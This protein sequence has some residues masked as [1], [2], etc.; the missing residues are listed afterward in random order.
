MMHNGPAVEQ[1]CCVSECSLP[2]RAAV[3]PD[4]LPEVFLRDP[5]LDDEREFALNP[6]H[7]HVVWV[8]HNRFDHVFDQFDDCRGVTSRCRDA[9]LPV[10]VCASSLP[11]QA[12]QECTS[13]DGESHQVYMNMINLCTK[14]L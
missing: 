13:Q 1:V 9:E 11:A 5:Q 8:V 2:N 12:W 6:V 14:L 3:F 4:H 7:A 10:S